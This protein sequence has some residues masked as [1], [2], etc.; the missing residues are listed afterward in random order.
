MKVPQNKVTE[1]VIGKEKS[2]RTDYSRETYN[3]MNRTHQKMINH[4]MKI[5]SVINK[6]R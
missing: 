1:L 4:Y 3:N 2:D 5:V 6:I